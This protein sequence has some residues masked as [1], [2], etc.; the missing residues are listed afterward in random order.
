[1]WNVAG[2]LVLTIAALRARSIALAGFGLD[3]LIEIGASTVVLWELGGSG[4]LRQRSALRMIGGAFV[5]LG[6]YMGGQSTWALAADFHPRHSAWD[7]VD[8]E[9]RGRDVLPSHRESPDRQAAGQP[10]TTH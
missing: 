3:S 4:A 10:G 9:H 1:M 7:R 8:R 5:A 2:V 6:I